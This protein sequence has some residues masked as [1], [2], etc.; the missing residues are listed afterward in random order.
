M[1]LCLD[2]ETQTLKDGLPHGETNLLGQGATQGPPIL[3]PTLDR[4]LQ[5]PTLDRHLQAPTLDRHL[6]APTLD[7]RLQ[8]PTLDRRLQEPTL[9]RCLQEP[10]LA[11]QHLLI[12][13]QLHQEPTLGNQVGLGSILLLDSQV[14]LEPTLLLAPL[15][16]LLDHW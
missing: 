16:S 3:V 14:L 15:A 6:Q 9:D 10:T 8:E 7:R 1:M 2:L 5:A 11:P 12:L 4:H 13:H